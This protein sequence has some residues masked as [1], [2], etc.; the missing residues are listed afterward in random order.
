MAPTIERFRC[1]CKVNPHIYRF[2]VINNHIF[3]ILFLGPDGTLF[4]GPDGVHY[5]EA[6]HCICKVNPLIT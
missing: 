5:G 4:L 3:G 6:F 2:S 1:I